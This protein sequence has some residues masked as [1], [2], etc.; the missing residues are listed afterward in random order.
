MNFLIQFLT[1]TLPQLTGSKKA[2]AAVGGSASA[3][4]LVPT[5]MSMGVSEHSSIIISVTVGV[6]A[7]V[8]V[9]IQGLIDHKTN[10][11]KI[12]LARLM[13]Q[14]AL[15]ADQLKAVSSILEVKLPTET[16]A[17]Q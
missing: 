3:A 11:N 10:D 17:Q 4:A 6:L 15:T 9:A 14:N 16:P 12:E 1:G 7:M 13:V 5:L 2:T 8:Y